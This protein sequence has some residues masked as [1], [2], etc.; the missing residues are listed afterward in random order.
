M[1]IPLSEAVLDDGATSPIRAHERVVAA[2]IVGL[3]LAALFVAPVWVLSYGVT[4]ADLVSLVVWYVVAAFGVTIGYHRLLTHQSFETGRVMRALL[5]A[6]GSIALQGPA[7]RWVADHRRHH[8]FSDREGDP[9]SPHTGGGFLHAHVGWLFAPTRTSARRYVPDLL[10]D[11]IV[12]AIDRHYGVM[13]LAS[14]GLP[15]LVGGLFGGTWQAAWAGLFWGGLVRTGLLHQTTW[16]VN[17]V[18]HLTGKR[19]WKT[20]D[21]STNHALVALVTL[22]EGWHNNHH[23]FPTSARHGFM[24]G[25]FD[26]SWGLIRL[27][28]RLGLAKNPRLPTDEQLRRRAAEP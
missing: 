22:G 11:P 4:L 19:P 12:R 15:A 24:R 6:C 21:Q 17:S 13:V 16:A 28:V 14:L 9:H 18:T 25:Q 7:I 3:P 8:A 1:S 10:A 20:R 23:A 5:V 27:L 26:P 2:A